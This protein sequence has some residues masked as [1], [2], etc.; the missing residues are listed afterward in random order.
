MNREEKSIAKW[1]FEKLKQQRKYFEYADASQY[2]LEQQ[3]ED[4]L[5]L[6]QDAFMEWIGKLKKDDS[7][8]TELNLL[9]KSIWRIQSY[10]GTLETICRASIVKFVQFEKNVERL[11]S[12]KRLLELKIK[13]MKAKHEIEKNSLEKE[14]E[15]ITK[16]SKP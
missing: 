15:F 8:S 16:N 14:I 12:E 2:L 9:L 11:E 5:L 7:R 13:Q 4:D 10:C 3:K 1:E 6:L